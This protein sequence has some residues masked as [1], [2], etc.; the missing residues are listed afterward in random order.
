M[1]NYVENDEFLEEIRKTQEKG[2]YTEKIGKILLNIVDGIGSRPNFSNYTWLEEM[3]GDA[4]IIALKAVYSY[5][6]DHPK[7]NPFGYFS[8]T[9]W[10]SFLTT[11]KKENQKGKIKTKLFDEQ[12]RINLRKDTFKAIDYSEVKD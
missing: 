6:I 3:K 5:D 11:I 4:L 1:S 7:N 2:K 10:W 8:R 12:D 9:I